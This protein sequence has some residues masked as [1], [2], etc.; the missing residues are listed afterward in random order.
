M[1]ER[2]DSVGGELTEICFSRAES[3]NLTCRGPQH[4]VP[5]FCLLR[6]EISFLAARETV[7]AESSLREGSLFCC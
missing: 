6:F 7:E 5:G 2:K 4:P 3:I 1:K